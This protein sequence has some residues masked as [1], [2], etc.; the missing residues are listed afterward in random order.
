MEFAPIWQQVYP[1]VVLLTLT[2]AAL[3]AADFVRPYWTRPRAL[4]RL[5]I[6][7]TW[8]FVC[9]FLARA[10]DLFLSRYTGSEVPEAVHLDRVADVINMSFQIGFAVAA[11]ITVF[12]IGTSAAPIE[13]P[14]RHAALVRLGDGARR[15]VASRARIR[16]LE[17]RCSSS[18]RHSLRSSSPWA[19]FS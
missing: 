14:A 19:V 1:L 5:A 17:T 15:T 13:A 3:A 9:S 16:L 18:S 2:T 8:L 10:G 4:M 12:E 7:V 11:V 6:N